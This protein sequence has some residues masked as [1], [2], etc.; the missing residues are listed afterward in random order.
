MWPV[1]QYAMVF[2]S[3]ILL[4]AACGGGAGH[5]AREVRSPTPTRLMSDFLVFDDS[6][7]RSRIDVFCSA[8]I[9]EATHLGTTEAL[10]DDRSSDSWTVETQPVRPR[11]GISL[12]YR[13]A[14]SVTAAGAPQYTGY[15]GWLTYNAFGYRDGV[16]QEFGREE[17]G[18]YSYSH[19]L[20]TNT[21]PP[22]GGTWRGVMVGV[23]IASTYR[24]HTVEGD[25]EVR[26]TDFR[27]S[28]VDVSFTQIFDADGSQYA[29]MTWVGL[30]L[31]EGGFRRGSDRDSIEGKFYGP[32]H[33][34]VG[35]MF[36]RNR[37]LGAF[38][39]ERR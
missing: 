10:G 25:A 4:L 31:R 23:D 28:Q 14:W 29:A 22:G 19:G 8:D 30:P 24:A 12:A 27:D 11:N 17:Q 15:G 16:R 13:S 32:N 9:C 21:N 6:G 37:I 36:E 38:G 2:G 5:A 35:G 33:E 7:L 39:A 1:F 34:E 3:V 18:V 26:M 20:A